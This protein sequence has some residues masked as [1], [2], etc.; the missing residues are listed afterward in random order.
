MFAGMPG[1]I[2][3]DFAT[4]TPG[5]PLLTGGDSSTH[6]LGIPGAPTAWYAQIPA[7]QNGANLT[8]ASFTGTAGKF[9]EARQ[10]RGNRTVLYV[11]STLYGLTATLDHT[12]RPEK[13]F[14]YA[15]ATIALKRDNYTFPTSLGFP[16][17][18]GFTATDA[19]NPFRTNVTPGF[20]GVPVRVYY[21]PVDIPDSSTLQ[22]RNGASLTL[23]IKGNLG[24]RWNWTL[25]ANGDYA[26]QGSDAYVPVNYL[27]TFVTRPGP[28]DSGT[29]T[30]APTSRAERLAIYNP[31]ADRNAFP[32]STAD[33]NR[34]FA[35][36][37]ANV[38]YQRTAQVNP[39]LGGKLYDLPAGS[40]STQLRGEV[41]WEQAN[42]SQ[43][44]PHSEE[45][46]RMLGLTPSLAPTSITRSSST[47]KAVA[48]EL[49]MPVFG[50]RFRPIP[51]ESAEVQAS[52]RRNWTNRGRNG[53]VSS[54]AGQVWLTRDVSLRASLSEGIRPLSA[55]QI[56]APTISNDFQV[57]VT[58]PLR[59]NTAQT[60]VIPTYV[61]GGNP[62]LRNE[63]SRTR[64]VGVIFKPRFLEDR[65]NLTATYAE[66]KRFDAVSTV[67]ITNILNFPDDYPG[68][69]ERAPLTAADQAAGYRGGAITRL[70]LTQ[71]NLAKTYVET[72]DLRGTLRLTDRQSTLG[73]VQ[74]TSLATFTNRFITQARPHAARIN[75]I[76]TVGGTTV[77]GPLKWKGN[78]QLWWTRDPWQAGLT[79]RYTDKYYTDQ[80]RPTPSIPTASGLD[81][82]HIPSVITWDLQ[83][84]YKFAYAADRRG[85]RS[86][87]TGTQW[88]L[89]VRN[90]LDRDPPF[91]SDAGA[92]FYSRYE[93]PRGRFVSLQIKKSL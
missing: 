79:A 19:L 66:T 1:Y 89:N 60:V 16:Y 90:L 58:D 93:D 33:V 26:R 46:D 4:S 51:V 65:L 23:G 24:T 6:P 71:I 14:V 57:S 2:K 80:T 88:I 63:F 45:M 85:W 30:R 87:F 42:S 34:L 70:D 7:N 41:R 15:E 54:V 13:L 77:N 38:N 3:S 39:R 55:T 78:I 83:L 32:I 17:G 86:W 91:R 69:L 12:L 92:G 59:G 29:G 72:I 37:R 53:D 22:E 8:P 68:R 62:G 11:P 84:G 20:V 67:S 56:Q 25:D 48:M 44:T 27:Q 47:T 9:N 73:T 5:T 43:F 40:I 31:L 81:G 49:V 35:F 36:N 82:D 21:D 61:T 75:N 10:W 64:S 74:L 52:G 28:T 18:L 76:S 50:R